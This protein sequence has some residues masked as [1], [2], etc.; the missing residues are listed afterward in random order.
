MALGHVVVQEAVRA[1]LCAE[2][3][4]RFLLY[5]FFVSKSC[6]PDLVAN[7][8]N[9]WNYRGTDFPDTT[10]QRTGLGALCYHFNRSEQENSFALK[11]YLQNRQKS[12]KR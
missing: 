3:Y 6:K 5:L 2:Q 7:C 9:C 10:G 1:R 4:K 12:I 11:L 8:N